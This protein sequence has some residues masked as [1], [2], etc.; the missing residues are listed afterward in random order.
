[1]HGGVLNGVEVAA[2]P[3]LRSSAAWLPQP[4]SSFPVASNPVYIPFSLLRVDDTFQ[5]ESET[6]E[7]DRLEN[8]A[9]QATGEKLVALALHEGSRYCEDGDP[10]VQFVRGSIHLWLSFFLKYADLFS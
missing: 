3:S 7:V 8:P 6:L 2:D 5:N 9:V 10:V 4:A 1:M